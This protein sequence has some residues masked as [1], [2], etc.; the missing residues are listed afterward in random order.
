MVPVKP[1]DVVGSRPLLVALLSVE[2]PPMA[3]IPFGRKPVANVEKDSRCS[4]TNAL[5]RTMLAEAPAT[6]ENTTAAP[7]KD[8]AVNI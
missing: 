6:A 5:M 4:P 8:R 7:K 3:L 2:M 1:H